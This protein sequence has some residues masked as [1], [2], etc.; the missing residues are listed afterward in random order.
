MLERSIMSWC[1]AV[2]LTASLMVAPAQ[3]SLGDTVSSVQSDAQH[4]KASVRI[5]QSANYSVHELQATG[6][7]TVREYISPEGKV[8]GVAWQGAARPDLQQLLGTYYQSVVQAVQAEKAQH[9]GR[10]PISIQQPGLVV[11]MGGHQRAFSGR[12]YLP[13][14]M[15]SAVRAEEIR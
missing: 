3:A 1:A 6:G 15:P 4:L 2:V 5:T 12:A 13:S 14:M 8:F 9:P 11:Q 7:T 10:H